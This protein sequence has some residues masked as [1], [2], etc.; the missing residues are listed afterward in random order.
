M[1]IEGGTNNDIPT[2]AF[3]ALWPSHM[4]PTSKTFI[5]YRTNKEKQLGDRELIIE[6]GGVLGGGS[7]TNALMYSRAQRA[8]FDSW[9]IPGWTA[10]EML[11]YLRKVFPLL[12]KHHDIK[13]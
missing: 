5:R 12:L 11:P 13:Y 2:V 9:E 8:D 1:V 10:N 4:M 6:S 3:P 7:S